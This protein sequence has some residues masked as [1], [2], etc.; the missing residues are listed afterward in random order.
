MRDL[1][2]VIHDAA[3][4][5]TSLRIPYAIVGGVAANLFGRGRSTF[6]VEVLAKLQADDPARLAEAFAGRGFRVSDDSV[7]VAIR[8]RGHF[9]IIDL[10]SDYRLDCKVAVTPRELRAIAGRRRVRVGRRFVYIDVPENVIVTSLLLGSEQDI[11][12]AEA[13]YARQRRGLNLYRLSARARRLGL[14]EEYYALRRRIDPLL[15]EQ[16]GR[17]APAARLTSSRTPSARRPGRR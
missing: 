15:E 17:R 14:L 12:D 10:Q 3:S 6:D 1:V 7:E 5:F 4:A 2:G 16:E 13:V 11:L 8:E 9:S